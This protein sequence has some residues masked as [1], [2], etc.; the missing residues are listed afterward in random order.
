VQIEK[1][2]IVDTLRMMGRTDVAD[3]AEQILPDQVDPSQLTQLLQEQ[4]IN[5]SE[6]MSKLRMSP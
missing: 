5:P 1:S 2:K 6:L 4:G 3:R